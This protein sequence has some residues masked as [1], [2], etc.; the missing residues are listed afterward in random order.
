MIK[1]ED[2]LNNFKETQSLLSNKDTLNIFKNLNTTLNNYINYKRLK[3]VEKAFKKIHYTKI[4]EKERFRR[5]K[6]QYIGI[7]EDSND[8]S[9]FSIRTEKHLNKEELFTRAEKQK[10]E[11]KT[12]D[13]QSLVNSFVENIRNEIADIKLKDS[14]SLF[15]LKRSEERLL[16]T[17]YEKEKYKLFKSKIEKRFNSKDL[18]KAFNKI[19]YKN[20]SNEKVKELSLKITGSS[21]DFYN[22]I[23]KH[24]KKVDLNDIIY[25]VNT[26]PLLTYLACNIKTMPK[27]EKDRIENFYQ[28]YNKELN[29]IENVKNYF[30]LDEKQLDKISKLSWQKYTILK[31]RPIILIDFIKL[32]LDFEKIQKREDIKRIYLYYYYLQSNNRFV[33]K[34]QN[35]E[36]AADLNVTR[37]VAK[38]L[39]KI[40]QKEMYNLGRHNRYFLSGENTHK[41]EIKDFK[42]TITRMRLE[43]IKSILFKTTLNINNIEYKLIPEIVEDNPFSSFN[44]VNDN[45]EKILIKI[46]GVTRNGLTIE[47]NLKDFN[48]EEKINEDFKNLFNQRVKSLNYLNRKSMIEF[49]QKFF[50][51]DFQQKT[52]NK[53]GLVVKNKGSR[54]REESKKI[55]KIISNKRFD[56]ISESLSLYDII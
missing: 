14:V 43:D 5:S 29:L 17:A 13:L 56:E 46:K 55:S 34:T 47:T 36:E 49:L 11:Y 39:F 48:L 31:N 21:S 26:Y 32:G 33:I 20:L 24:S 52:K 37:F 53:F 15:M 19:I 35:L 12:K 4:E 44:Y 6:F 9:I 7:I 50:R 3:T 40:Y 10:K 25:T 8:F 23:E 28:N 16:S 1:L 18:M 54:Y 45:N 41:I 22:S 27:R 38:D 2:F 30:A 42:E 51:K